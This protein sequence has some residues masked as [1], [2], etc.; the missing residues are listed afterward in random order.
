M[1][2]KAVKWPAS[3]VS[4]WLNIPTTTCKEICLRAGM[5][6]KDGFDIL[7]AAPA[8]VAHY[9]ELSERAGQEAERDRAR[10]SKAE[11]NMAELAEEKMAGNLASLGE[12][13]RLFEC[14]IVQ[15]REGVRKMKTLDQAQKRAV[16]EV[17]ASAKFGALQEE[18]DG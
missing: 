1:S 18:F 4:A 5:D 9:K 6:T 12:C 11:A 10:K 16:C 17:L 15:T 8:V 14:A 3:Q 7:R 2:E 13:R